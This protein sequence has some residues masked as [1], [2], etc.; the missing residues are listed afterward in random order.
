MNKFAI[1]ALIASTQ[2][3]TVVAGAKEVSPDYVAPT[4]LDLTLSVM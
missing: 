4:A 2:A 1:L 3:A